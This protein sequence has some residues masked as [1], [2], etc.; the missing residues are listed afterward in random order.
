MP[1]CKICN[2]DFSVKGIG[3]HLWRAHTEQGIQHKL[4]SNPWNKGLTKHTNEVVNN[5]SKEM[6]GNTIYKNWKQH[7]WLGKTHSPE[8]K[9]K[10]SK[11]LSINNKGGRCKWFEV[12]GQKVQGS[13]E[14]NV[15]LKLNELGIRWQKLKTNRH[16][17]QYTLN[18]KVKSYTPDFYLPDFDTYLEIK[19]RWWGDDK[20]K[21]DAVFS[22]YPHIKICVIEKDKYDRIM[23]GEQVW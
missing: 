2:K 15:A 13:W 23:L 10:L 22:Q 7:P 14:K 21:M 20:L 3:T 5:K 8:T 12:S 11:S 4:K 1:I 18:A 19:G 16:T 9:L 17:I 6:I